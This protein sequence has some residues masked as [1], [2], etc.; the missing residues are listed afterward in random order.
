MSDCG[1]VSVPVVTTALDGDDYHHTL[2]LGATSLRYL[3]KSGFTVR[4]VGPAWTEYSNKGHT[5]RVTP[6]LARNKNWS[7]MWSAI[8]H[9][10]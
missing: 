4:V 7:V 10:C 1:F 3:T 2:T 9:V 5:W 8:G 6:D